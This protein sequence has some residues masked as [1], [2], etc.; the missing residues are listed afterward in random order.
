MCSWSHMHS[1]LKELLVR[2][3]H[4]MDCLDY[5]NRFVFRGFHQVVGFEGQRLRS[6]MPIDGI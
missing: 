1:C 5:W 2:E 3:S 4:E 6:N